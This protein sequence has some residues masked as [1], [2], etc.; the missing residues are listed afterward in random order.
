[1]NRA[2]GWRFLE[3]GRARSA[4]S[5]PRG[6]P[7]FAHDEAGDETSTSADAGDCQITYRSRYL[8]GPALA[9]VRDPRCS[10]P[11]TARSRFRSCAER[12]H[13][14]LPTLKEQA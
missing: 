2:A 12:S 1:M 6:S 5:T 10:I 11:I 3:M 14:S 4:P 13:R 7:Q 8:V 9:P